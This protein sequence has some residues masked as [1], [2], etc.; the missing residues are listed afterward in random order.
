MFWIVFDQLFFQRLGHLGDEFLGRLDLFVP[1]FPHSHG[2]RMPAAEGAA[3]VWRAAGALEAPVLIVEYPVVVSGLP[4]LFDVPD[5]DVA[6]FS[7][8]QD[9]GVA[10]VVHILGIAAGHNHRAVLD[11]VG[12]EEKL[13]L[14]GGGKFLEFAL[15]RHFALMALEEHYGP[16]GNELFGKK[17]LAFVFDFF[18]CKKWS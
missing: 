3:A 7:R 4:A 17:P 5:H 8:V 12:M 9:V 13:L 2:Q 6:T 18:Y 15:G 10:A 14:L 16:P 1:K 11:G